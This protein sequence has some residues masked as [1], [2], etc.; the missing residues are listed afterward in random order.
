MTTTVRGNSDDLIDFEGDLC[1]E[2]GCYGTD[3]RPRGVLLVF[4]DGTVLEAK[5]CARVSGVWSFALLHRGKLLDRIDTCNR[6]DGRG[7]YSD[8][9]YFKDGLLRAWAAKEDWEEVS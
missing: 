6:D 5:Y 2:V 8:V 7:D 3:D 4:D 9:V 1:G